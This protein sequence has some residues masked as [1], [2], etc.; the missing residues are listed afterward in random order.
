MKQIPE[1]KLEG[2]E[3]LTPL[4]M[5]AIHFDAGVRSQYVADSL[6]SSKADPVPGAGT[7]TDTAVKR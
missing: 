3:V 6:T 4:E 7:S 2:A 1:V 5:N